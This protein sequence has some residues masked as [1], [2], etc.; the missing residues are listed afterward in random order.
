M[1]SKW[2]D[3][4]GKIFIVTS[5]L[6]LS[7][8]ALAEIQIT[9]TRVIFPANKKEVSVTLQNTGKRPVLVQSWVDNTDQTAQLNI[10]ESSP[11]LVTPPLSRVEPGQYAALRILRIAGDFPEDRE[12]HFWLNVQ[13]IPETTKAENALQLALTSRLKL[14]I[15]PA[16]LEAPTD[17]T[18]AKLTW[19]V[20]LH[21][22][23]P[24]LQVFNP[25]P[26]FITITGLHANR[27]IEI[28]T[29]AM[30][31]PLAQMLYPIP[32]QR[33]PVE[34]IKTL[35]YQVMND[36]G[37]ETKAIQVTLQQYE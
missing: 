19:K 31:P 24:V 13:E 25:T 18:Y 34:Q 22:R 35:S 11:F 7:A 17:T 8:Y 21:D 2:F 5:I 10:D 36:F 23:Q 12:S 28:P 16:M 33:I 4:I 26:Y 6:L 30:L 3:G 32:P 37:A 20:L 15:R 14:F 9:G 29:P 27:E 1:L